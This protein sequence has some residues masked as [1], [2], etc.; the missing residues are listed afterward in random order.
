MSKSHHGLV[1]CPQPWVRC[2]CLLRE[3]GIRVMESWE[4]RAS[5][6]LAGAQCQLHSGGMQPADMIYQPSN[7]RPPLYLF[8]LTS[9]SAS[10]FLPCSLLPLP[11]S[12]YFPRDFILYPIVHHSLPISLPLPQYPLFPL[13]LLCSGECPVIVSAPSEAW[14]SVTAGRGRCTG[15]Y[16]NLWR[17]GWGRGGHRCLWHCC[18]P[19]CSTQLPHTW[20]PH[21]RQQ[22]HV[23]TS[24]EHVLH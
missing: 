13:P 1:C 2:S 3:Y 19:E 9:L 18:T 22:E 4:N 5:I 14:L 23:S 17:W 7:P 8:C 12:F 24:M 16:H 15:E 21:T 6:C 20:L 10:N 11:L